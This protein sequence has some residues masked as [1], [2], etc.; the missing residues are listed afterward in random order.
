MP[1]R[2]S[3]RRPTAWSIII[4]ALALFMF[5]LSVMAVAFWDAHR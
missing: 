3:R 1:T 5:G 4:F 2:T